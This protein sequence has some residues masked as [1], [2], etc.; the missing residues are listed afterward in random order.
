[1]R[2]VIVS[3]ALMSFGLAAPAC[4]C[5]VVGPTPTPHELVAK[6]EVIVRARAVRISNHPGE[7]GLLAGAKTQVI[8]TVVDVLKGRLPD[9]TIE[10]NGGLDDTDDPN[11]MPVPYTFVRPGGRHGDC[12]AMSY[13]AGREYLLLL[14][15]GSHPAYAQPNTLTPY[16]TPLMPTNEQV[17]GPDD[18][19]VGWVKRALPGS[20]GSRRRTR[21]SRQ[22]APHSD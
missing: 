9:A 7:A 3:A 2:R 8:F 19:W 15:R 10:F 11:D 6:A 12:F 18:P 16:W 22:S 17:S 5:T 4:P 1:M 14:T 21:W 20:G 13:R